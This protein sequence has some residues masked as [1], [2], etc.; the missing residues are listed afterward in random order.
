M[1]GC[2]SGLA[3]PRPSPHDT[4]PWTILA[5]SLHRPGISRTSRVLWDYGTADQN[6]SISTADDVCF[7][8]FAVK[9]FGCISQKARTTEHQLVEQTRY[10]FAV[11]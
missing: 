8:D 9:D 10:C 2:G 6:V 7:Q 4:S 3:G 5:A 1:F 11:W